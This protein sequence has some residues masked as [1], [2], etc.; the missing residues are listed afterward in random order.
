MAS[1]TAGT[2]G[3]YKKTLGANTV[4]TVTLPDAVEEVSIIS[5]GSAA[6]YVTVDGTTPTVEGADTWEIPAAGALVE[7]TLPIG[8]DAH[9]FDA[10]VDPIVKLISA[11]TPVYSVRR[12]S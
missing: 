1:Y 11:G 4:D 3:I 12:T 9:R 6:I 7:L 5:D 8:V 2:V 10:G